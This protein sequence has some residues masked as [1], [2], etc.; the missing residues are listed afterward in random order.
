MGKLSKILSVKSI[1]VGLMVAPA[2]YAAEKGVHT[3][4]LDQWES[5]TFDGAEVQVLQQAGIGGAADL[6][7][8][9]SLMLNRVDMD[10]PFWKTTDFVSRGL[11]IS[12]WQ[13]PGLIVNHA[14]DFKISWSVYGQKQNMEADWEKFSGNPLISERGWSF[15]RWN[16]LEL[17][18]YFGGQPNSQSLIRGEE[19]FPEELKN[20][21][22]MI[23]NVGEFAEKGWAMAMADS[24]NPL[25]EGK[26]P[27][28]LYEEY[29]LTKA[30]GGYNA[31]SDWVNVNGVWYAPDESRDGVSRMWTSENLVHWK[32]NGPVKGQKGHDAGAVWDGEKFY[33][34]TQEGTQVLVNTASDP[35]GEWTL[36]GAVDQVSSEQ[37]LVEAAEGEEG[38][39]ESTADSEAKMEAESEEALST[40]YEIPPKNTGVALEV[41]E[42][43]SDIE[44]AYFNNR[45]HMFFNLGEENHYRIAY[46]STTAEAFPFGWKMENTVL[47]PTGGKQDQKWDDDST[48]GN[49]YGIGGADVV[50]EDHA[51]YLSYDKPIGIAYKNLNV[52]DAKEQEVLMR[53]EYL[54]VNDVVFSGEWQNLKP[55]QSNFKLKSLGLAEDA[56]KWRVMLEL[57]SKNPQET[58]IIEKMHWQ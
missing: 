13:E 25:Q 16:T 40:V 32:L 58:P 12:Q 31:P 14:K 34:F 49:N 23:F 17:P 46:A 57:K 37:P 52:F 24:L 47:S 38:A 35:L 6:L 26:N 20:K 43:V 33:L 56:K 50:I 30:T 7:N 28:K 53:I 41:G 48:L 19:H 5:M 36:A 21:W 1:L 39:L 18:V 11:W 8:N 51:L 27:F 54:D 42:P 4:T 45:W 2:G 9:G 3:D 44:V 22:L 10:Q 29:P 15:A 55:G